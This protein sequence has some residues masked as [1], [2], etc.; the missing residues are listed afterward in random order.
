MEAD[1]V[2]GEH[3]RVDLLP[4]SV[5]EDPPRVRL[6]P[7]DVNEVVEE[8]VGTRLPD[9]AWTGVEV[10]VVEHHHRALLV[11]DRPDHRGG[12]VVV[13]HLVALLPGVHLGLPDVRRVGEVPE[14]VLDEPEDRVGD[15]VVEA[16]VGRRIRDDHLNVVGDRVQLDR[17]RTVALAGDD[18]VLVG[19][20]GGDPE[21]LAVRDEP[22]E[23]R[24]EPA[25]TAVDRAIAAVVDAELRGA[26]IR[27]DRQGMRVG[28]PPFVSGVIQDFESRSVKIRSQSSSRRG[29]RKRS[30][31]RSLPARP[32]LRPSSGSWRISVARLAASSGD[33]TR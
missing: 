1:D 14:V 10:V 30:R 23:R 27:D 8:G 32:S 26:A 12:H 24:D 28:T 7:G 15:H 19:Q 5:G 4:P 33:E 6:R 13:D 3:A 17:H 22:G 9:Q 25:A 31:V 2:V 18:D 20:R 21:R 11:L 29:V 16:V